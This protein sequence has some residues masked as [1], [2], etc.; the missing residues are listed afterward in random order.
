VTDAVLT[1]S[2][3]RATW[4]AIAGRWNRRISIVSAL[5]TAAVVL[6]LVWAFAIRFGGWA[7]LLLGWWPAMLIASAAAFVVG[8]AWYALLLAAAA[9]FLIGGPGVVAG[10]ASAASRSVITFV[11]DHRTAS[12]TQVSQR[13][14][15]NPG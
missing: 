13:P 8:R 14:S 1:G 4:T 11:G 9:A 12:D 5:F 6:L 2:G 15:E 3:E 10:Q 7:G